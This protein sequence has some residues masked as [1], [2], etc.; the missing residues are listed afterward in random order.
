MTCKL[1]EKRERSRLISRGRL[2]RTK[3]I[4]EKSTGRATAVVVHVDWLGAFLYSAWD[5]QLIK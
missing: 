3:K 2:I 1:Y 4:Y 5:A